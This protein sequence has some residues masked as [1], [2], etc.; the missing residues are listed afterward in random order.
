MASMVG[1]GDFEDKIQ[2]SFYIFDEG[3]KGH[4]ANNEFNRFV[5]TLIQA[6]IKVNQHN[7]SPSFNEDLEKFSGKM[8]ALSNN[9][10]KID[11]D[12]IRKDLFNN[13]FLKYCESIEKAGGNSEGNKK[14]NEGNTDTSTFQTN[15]TAMDST[16]DLS[17][18]QSNRDLTKILDH[19]TEQSA[20]HEYEE[21]AL[22]EEQKEKIL[23]LKHLET[24]EARS[25]QDQEESPQTK[26][27]PPVDE[28]PQ[29]KVKQIIN[30][31]NQI[32]KEAN[33]GRARFSSRPVQ[34]ANQEKS[35]IAPKEDTDEGRERLASNVEY[36]NTESAKSLIARFNKKP[37]KE[38]PVLTRKTTFN[39]KSQ[40]SQL[41]EQGT[42]TETQ[43]PK[44]KPSGDSDSDS[45]QEMMK[46]MMKLKS[47][48]PT[49][50]NKTPTNMAE[51]LGEGSNLSP[52][53]VEITKD[54]SEALENFVS[55]F[56]NIDTFNHNLHRPDFSFD[57]EKNEKQLKHHTMARLNKVTPSPF[58]SNTASS[59]SQNQIDSEPSEISIPVLSFFE[60]TS[61][62]IS[63]Q[64][65]VKKNGPVKRPVNSESYQAL[66]PNHPSAFIPIE[67]W[68]EGCFSSQEIL[69]SIF[70]P[71]KISN[72]VSN[73][74][75]DS[76][77]API[78][79]QEK[80]EKPPLGFCN[81]EKKEQDS[82]LNSLP[83]AKLSRPLSKPLNNSGFCHVLYP[84]PILEV[85]NLLSWGM[86]EIN[87]NDESLTML[88]PVVTHSSIK[89]PVSSEEGY[90]SLPLQH[91]IQIPKLDL[92]NFE[93]NSEE[94]KLIN[95]IQT[96][97]KS[98]PLQKPFNETGFCQALYPV[99]LLEVPSLQIW[100]SNDKETTNQPTQASE[101][102]SF[103]KSISKPFNEAGS[104]EPLPP[105]ETHQNP[106]LTSW[107]IHLNEKDQQI[108]LTQN[109]V[110]HLKRTHKPINEAGLCQELFPQDRLQVP[111]LQFHI[112]TGLK[113]DT[114]L[115]AI[116][117]LNPS[118][119]I[120]KP[121]STEGSL[122]SLLH[123]TE[124]DKPVLE[125]NERNIFS[126]LN[127]PET[128]KTSPKVSKVLK[129]PFEDKSNLL[130][131]PL[132]N[133]SSE[134]VSWK[135]EL[136]EL[137]NPQIS[138]LHA[139]SIMKTIAVP[140]Q[141]GGAH[142]IIQNVEDHQNV[143]ANFELFGSV[144]KPALTQD[145][146][147]L[148]KNIEQITKPLFDNVAQP[149]QAEVGNLKL[150]PLSNA[151]QNNTDLGAE[152]QANV[153]IN[154]AIDKVPKPFHD[155]PVPALIQETNKEIPTLN[156][157]QEISHLL[158][159]SCKAQIAEKP[160]LSHQPIAK[161]NKAEKVLQNEI[162]ALS[163]K[164]DKIQGERI[165]ED[166]KAD[167]PERG[168]STIILDQSGS[169]KS[170][171]SATEWHERER[172]MTVSD[173]DVIEESILRSG[174][175]EMGKILAEQQAQRAEQIEKTY[176]Q[177]NTEG[178]SQKQVIY[179][180]DDDEAGDLNSTFVNMSAID[181]KGIYT[182]ID[183]TSSDNRLADKR[184]ADA[185]KDALK[186]QKGEACKMCNIF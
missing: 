3:N 141:K 59:L 12:N 134:K 88:N 72:K 33:Q 174:H 66:S 149:L 164:N 62:S 6:T 38:E 101:T 11:F 131:I 71:V 111:L 73:P 161:L 186:G 169:E 127:M 133:S 118:T 61:D 65:T 123:Q 54:F 70:P 170:Y 1:Q 4:L 16:Q 56:E 155:N 28:S 52:T 108:P 116:P 31:A 92:W 180:E 129:K 124:V 45:E 163:R 21:E 146:A 183:E 139:S 140:I 152:V 144:N 36:V 32:D 185:A 102:I 85:P 100:N 17:N 40:D 143:K 78:S 96:I 8:I 95:S 105:I 19:S 138:S 26:A 47:N 48:S 120:R 153:T 63:S 148:S 89:K 41:E 42:E 142:P 107:E 74:F 135:H 104:Y 43:L 147:K 57:F 182:Q 20:L 165:L 119:I 58:A 13:S 86:Q 114:L 167:E 159:K 34:F 177:T 49:K 50:M 115:K 84:Q 18:L 69:T 150:S 151:L 103:S 110:S 126:S 99:P 128:Q 83:I 53:K 37:T 130:P 82:P 98:F 179:D 176:I 24:E 10:E 46:F 44:I 172:D 60:K 184:K 162:T 77:L 112:K 30:Q 9:Q 156:S 27:K 117:S 76:F 87:Q 157:L 35:K 2:T 75:N 15:Q 121:F 97:P 81:I 168:G 113:E 154:K 122:T 166:N 132:Q 145:L 109:I 91:S 136:F 90:Q 64:G 171:R 181:Q 51:A 158:N 23:D 106:T 67:G 94:N 93:K 160:V 68:K 7:I 125:I 79:T 14:I 29:S 137:S 55:P 173:T 5:Q 25:Q 80:I 22:T 178:V 175:H 39:P